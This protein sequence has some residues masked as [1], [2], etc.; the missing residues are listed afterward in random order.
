L[1]TSKYLFLH[2]ELIF[3]AGVL[4]LW[5]ELRLWEIVYTG[6]VLWFRVVVLR[7]VGS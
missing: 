7:W 5:K 6:Y 1:E 2:P 4:Y 3:E